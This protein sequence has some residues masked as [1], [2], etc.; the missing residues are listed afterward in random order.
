MH[1]RTGP[2]CDGHTR[3]C[4]Q[5]IAAIAE[6]AATTVAQFIPLQV[7]ARMTIGGKIVVHAQLP[8]IDH[9]RLSCQSEGF[10]LL[11]LIEAAL[12]VDNLRMEEAGRRELRTLLRAH[13]ISIERVRVAR[14]A[15]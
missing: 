5:G 8:D 14:A 2:T 3:C 10:S 6:I 4:S 15:M 12:D 7:S 1:F 13:E 11:E 9:D